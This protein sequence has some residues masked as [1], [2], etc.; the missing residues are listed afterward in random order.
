MSLKMVKDN[1]KSSH[2]L[3]KIV[4]VNKPRQFSI[5]SV[6]YNDRRNIVKAG[7]FTVRCDEATDMSF[8]QMEALFSS[9]GTNL[10]TCCLLLP[11]EVKY[12]KLRVDIP[13]TCLILAARSAALQ[14]MAAKV[15]PSPLI[16]ITFDKMIAT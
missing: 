7:P 5:F 2:F 1:N 13:L 9:F 4:K 12:R 8:M 15:W 10:L 3:R 6:N 14:W 11:L 16:S